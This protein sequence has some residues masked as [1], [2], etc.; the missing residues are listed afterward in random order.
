VLQLKE[1][2][3]L[4][5]DFALLKMAARDRFSTINYLKKLSSDCKE[6][7]NGDMKTLADRISRFLAAGSPSI[8]QQDNGR[9][10]VM[11]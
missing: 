6:T 11:M 1:R 5:A 9:K 4:T 2:G 3:E 8:K 7:L 10:V